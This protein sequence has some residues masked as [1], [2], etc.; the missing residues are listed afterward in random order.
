MAAPRR[1]RVRRASTSSTSQT[2]AT[3]AAATVDTSTGDVDVTA[4][5]DLGIQNIAGGGAIT[6]TNSGS[7]DKSV[8]LAIGVNFVDNTTD[9]SIAAGAEVA[10]ATGDVAVLADASIKPTEIV[11]PEV[12]LI[13]EHTGIKVT[14]LVVGASVGA[15]SGW[16]AAGS[17]A[18]NVFDSATHAS[19][20]AGAQ[21]SAGD[22]VEVRATDDTKINNV[23]G[24]LAGS[25]EGKA[26]GIGLDVTVLTKDTEATIAASDTPGTRHR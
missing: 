23:V 5:S 1:W 2:T 12:P 25:K 26:L 19:I 20:G 22:D 15:A 17:A 14:T 11:L 21:V 8:G 9:A 3:I 18:V 16:A 10:S 4:R 13:D 6:K 7:N 24:A